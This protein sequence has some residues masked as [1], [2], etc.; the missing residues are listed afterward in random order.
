MQI[1]KEIEEGPKFQ[2]TLIANNTAY[3]PE[4]SLARFTKVQQAQESLQM[5]EEKL[6]VQEMLYFDAIVGMVQKQQKVNNIHEMEARTH[7]PFICEK[8]RQ[9]ASERSLQDLIVESLKF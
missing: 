6:S 7:Y 2:P 1:T 5:K 9:I 3:L 4:N 8:S